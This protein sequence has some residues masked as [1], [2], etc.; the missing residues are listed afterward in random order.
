[1]T[2]LDE[3]TEQRAT[4]I[5]RL[6][7]LRL[8]QTAPISRLSHRVRDVV[9]L[10][11]SS[12]GGSSV[13]AEILRNS[14]H[15]LH[16]RAE[17]NP[18]LLL[19]GHAW[20]ESGR[21]NDSLTA[22]DLGDPSRL[23]HLLAHDLG[24]HAGTLPNAQAVRDFAVEL[25]WRLSL[26]WPLEPFDPSWVL[27][28]ARH[29]LRQL[30]H[31]HGWAPGTFPDAA[32]FHAIF[33]AQVRQR[34]PRVNPWY[35]DLPPQLIQQHCPD[36]HPSL[37]PPSAV[38]LEEPPFVT[39]SP[40]QAATVEELE[41]LP[42]IIK[43]PS[44]VYRLPFLAAL[45]PNARVRVL[46]L[47][48]NAAASVNGLVDGWRFRGFFAHRL[49]RELAI[50]G[51]S[52]A[53]HTWSRAW[54]KF[55]LP[56]GWQDWTENSL[57]EVCGFQWRSAHRAVLDQLTAQPDIERITLPFERVVGNHDH[58]VE[59][60]ST[61]SRWLG[62]PGDATM[63]RLVSSGLPPIMAT[64]RPRHRRWYDKAEL[65]EP[66][67]ARDDTRAILDEL[68]YAPDPSTWL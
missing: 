20:P 23:E 6:L 9:V 32:R 59:A 4:A 63:D 62:L 19:A 18:F 38:V 66:V 39:V 15:L 3:A 1:M 51:Y 48:R 21:S 24:R 44:N 25:H 57:V 41:R 7:A 13:M 67:L 31:S 8:Q 29:T 61:L 14:G 33:L 49:D 56:P 64:S 45:F 43:T 26:Q 40:W 50:R 35:Y 11:S 30:E 34:H 28:Q 22:D 12:R 55:D 54:W 5:E 27:E 65:L 17:I 37:A 47:T 2:R 53:Q 46:H 58:R 60:F 52:Q 68:G 16:F 42:L 10:A 36:A